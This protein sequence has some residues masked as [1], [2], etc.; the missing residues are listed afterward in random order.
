MAYVQ[1]PRSAEDGGVHVQRLT[2]MGQIGGVARISID[3]ETSGDDMTIVCSEHNAARLLAILATI[4]GIRLN[5]TDAKGI[6][7]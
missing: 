6:K 1:P 2:G 4:L 3:V 7:L 5:M